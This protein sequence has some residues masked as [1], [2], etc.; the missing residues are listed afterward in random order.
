MA[1]SKYLA[2]MLT[3]PKFNNS[4]NT[5]VLLLLQPWHMPLICTSWELPVCGLA[6]LPCSSS[7]GFPSNLSSPG[8][9]L[10]PTSP[11]THGPGTEHIIQTCCLPH[12][13]HPDIWIPH[14]GMN[15][16]FSFQGVVACDPD[17]V[18]ELSDS[19]LGIVKL[20]IKNNETDTGVRE[21]SGFKEII[22]I[23]SL[24][25]SVT[26]VRNMCET[27]VS[28]LTGLLFGNSTLEGVRSGNSWGIVS[29]S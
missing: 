9:S 19:A 20:S 5:L 4:L 11:V 27:C 2:T 1:H 29:T 10:L 22:L 24:V 3:K 18:S 17:R 14:N 12:F 21:S 13:K 26:V 7:S 16:S 8:S 6:T 25:V 23:W 28:I 15:F